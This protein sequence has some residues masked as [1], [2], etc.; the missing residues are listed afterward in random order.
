MLESGRTYVVISQMGNAAMDLSDKDQRSII[1][2]HIHKGDNQRV[3]CD[4]WTIQKRRNGEYLDTD[5]PN[6]V[7]AVGESS[8]QV[9]TRSGTLS[10][11][12]DSLKATGKVSLHRPQHLFM[13][14]L[15]DYRPRN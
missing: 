6:V 12:A 13:V 15:Q 10:G 9:P 1:S 14:K 11:T 2:S 5:I 3:R 8:L 4:G 7:S